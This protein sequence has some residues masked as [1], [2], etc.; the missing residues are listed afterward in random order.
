ML[1]I[2]SYKKYRQN[3]NNCKFHGEQNVYE[4]KSI[5]PM[6]IYSWKNDICLYELIQLIQT[7]QKVN[8]L[9]INVNYKNT[10][11]KLKDIKIKINF[12]SQLM[13]KNV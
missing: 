5:L 9:I 11:T 13:L 2:S 8:K 10:R 6:L 3:K 7:N 4:L 12:N 1:T